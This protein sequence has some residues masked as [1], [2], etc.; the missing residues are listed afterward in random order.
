MSHKSRVSGREYL[1][2]RKNPKTGFSE[3]LIYTGSLTQKPK[4]WTLLKAL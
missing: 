2:S 4:G 3:T 1:L